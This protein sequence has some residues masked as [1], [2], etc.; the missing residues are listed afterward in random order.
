MSCPKGLQ[1]SSTPRSS[2]VPWSGPKLRH[3]CHDRHQGSISTVISARVYTSMVTAGSLARLPAR[4]G[5]KQQIR[6]KSRGP[7]L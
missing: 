7:R 6:G 2:D 5:N 3:E 4:K 1:C